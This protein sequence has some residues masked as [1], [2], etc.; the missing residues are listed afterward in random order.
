MPFST[1]DE[2]VRKVCGTIPWRFDPEY[3]WPPDNAK[4][5]ICDLRNFGED[6]ASEWEET[7]CRYNW[8]MEIKCGEYSGVTRVRVHNKPCD[9]ETRKSFERDNMAYDG[10]EYFM[11]EEDE[12]NEE[13][14]HRGPDIGYIYV[15]MYGE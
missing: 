3:G 12:D 1:T 13:W 5:P 15:E 10:W 14:Y 8:N 2:N 11:D 6:H 7:G 9:D 4:D